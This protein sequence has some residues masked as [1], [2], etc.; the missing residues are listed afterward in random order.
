MGFDPSKIPSLVAMAEA[1]MG[2]GDLTKVQVLGTP[3]EQCQFKFKPNEKII[4]SY[5]LK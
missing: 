2:Q 5:G 4:E 1:G 3:V